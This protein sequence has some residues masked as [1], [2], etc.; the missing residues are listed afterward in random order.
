M[1]AIEETGGRARE[2]APR[3]VARRDVLK[4]LG[5]GTIAAAMGGRAVLGRMT[6]GSV[7]VGKGT[8]PAAELLS[9][10]QKLPRA[11]WHRV[12]PGGGG[13]TFNPAISPYD[14]EMVVL[15]CD[16]TGCYGTYDGGESWGEFDLRNA[17]SFFAFDPSNSNTLYAGA[18]GLWRS[19]DRGLSWRLIW[20][21]PDTIDSVEMADWYAQG[22]GFI[23]NGSGVGFVSA[24][25]VD[26]AAASNLYLGL[27]NGPP[28][29]LLTSTDGGLSWTT[30]PTPTQE[31]VGGIFID[32]SSPASSRDVY[33]FDSSSLWVYSGGTFTLRGGSSPAG[34]YIG[35]A[36]GFDSRTGSAYLYRITQSS[37][38]VSADRGIT[39]SESM[40]P[41]T[42]YSIGALAGS[43]TVPTV[44]YVSYSSLDHS[45]SGAN[46]DYGYFGTARTSDGGKSWQLVFKDNYGPNDPSNV[47]G[48]WITKT[49]GS[50]WAGPPVAFGV[51]AQDPNLCYA[52]DFGRVFKTTN[53]GA[54]WDQVYFRQ[55]TPTSVTTTGLDVTNCYGIFFDPFDSTRQFLCNTDIGLLR[56]E[57]GGASWIPSTKG[58]PGAWLYNWYKVVF[59]PQV[60]G[61]VWGALSG[62]HD[63]PD[64]KDWQSTSPLTYQGGICASGDGGKT[65]QNSSSG[66]PELAPTDLLLDASSP[67]GAR[68]LYLAAM[69][70]GVYK[71]VDG[72]T[73][74]SAA[75][76]GITESEPMAWQIT[77]DANGVLYLVLYRRDYWSGQG[78][79]NGAVYRSVNAAASWEAVALPQGVT[80]PSGI[81]IDA[82]DP[83]RLYLATYKSMSVSATNGG[84]YMSTDGGS[85][86]TAVLA[87]DQH[88]YGVTQ[89]PRD[90]SRLYAAGFESNA[91]RSDDR[92]Y[93]WERIA[94][95]DFKWGRNVI[96]DPASVHDIYIATYGSSVWHGPAA[97]DPHAPQEIATPTLAY[98]TLL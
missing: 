72:G 52:T 23:V 90:P 68:V 98:G 49:F 69:G 14:R 67:V 95:Y 63:L 40:L 92:G 25:A 62:T 61:R 70:H 35:W 5:A 22:P 83:E 36:A 1:T 54:T 37:I 51:A 24:F 12:G 57:D 53:G 33:I 6:A 18:E 13:A 28:G 55:V 91:W 64:L 2:G 81:C 93:T 79:V 41:G 32:P 86:W 21:I 46:Y 4:G 15:G 11:K 7:H 71:S 29:T 26:P 56:S 65:W 77:M 38:F 27:S 73:T 3:G 78:V 42:G 44:A 30:V 96:C 10:S 47:S 34:T 20:P 76:S 84:I 17:A 59:D 75:N 80:G 31:G 74:W 43:A 89:D 94:G 66:L 82:G 16:M 58:S 45:G 8:A 85:T 97:G 19:V 9:S 48:D 60:Q 39:W 50:G 87:L 88:I